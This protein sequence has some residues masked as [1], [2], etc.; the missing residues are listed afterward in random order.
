MGLIK[1]HFVYTNAQMVRIFRNKVVDSIFRKGI[2]RAVHSTWNFLPKNKPHIGFVYRV[3]TYALP[4]YAY[5]YLSRK[6]WP[7][8]TVVR[9]PSYLYVLYPNILQTIWYNI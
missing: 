7:A 5:G 1:V 8:A 4:M 6:P 2:T 9:T 3:Y